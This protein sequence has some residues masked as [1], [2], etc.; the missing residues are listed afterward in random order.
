MQFAAFTKRT[1]LT[2]SF[3]GRSGP[4]GLT[5]PQMPPNQERCHG[6]R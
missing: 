1:F 5:G 6:N 3:L 2:V 4:A